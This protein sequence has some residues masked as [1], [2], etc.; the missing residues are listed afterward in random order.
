MSL[1][2]EERRARRTKNR[3]AGEE[4]EKDNPVAEAARESVV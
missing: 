2:Q 4:L 1:S 3:M